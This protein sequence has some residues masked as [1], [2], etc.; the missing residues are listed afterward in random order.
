[1]G[2]N[3]GRV[4]GTNK[5]SLSNWLLR[6]GSRGGV[7]VGCLH[8]VGQFDLDSLTPAIQLLISAGFGLLVRCGQED[9]DSGETGES[10]EKGNFGQVDS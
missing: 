5:R 10:Y 9:R 2:K 6:Q 4:K 8:R 7:P 1:M 3:L